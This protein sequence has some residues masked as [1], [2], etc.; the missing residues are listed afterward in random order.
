MS[1]HSPRAAALA[2]R[3]WGYANPRG[4]D[5]TIREI[6]SALGERAHRVQRILQNQKWLGRVR[7]ENAR[8]IDNR[9]NRHW[10]ELD[11]IL[12]IP[13]FDPTEEREAV[14]VFSTDK[15]GEE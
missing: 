14:S 1:A 13:L 10:A 12:A 6:A 8:I 11:G 3:I 7:T 2:Y 4:W 5:V 9:T 15:E